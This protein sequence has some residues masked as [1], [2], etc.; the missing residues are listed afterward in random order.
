MTPVLKPSLGL[1]VG[2]LY[3]IDGISPQEAVHAQLPRR[4]S[5]I[6]NAYAWDEDGKNF[7][8]DLLFDLLSY[9]LDWIGYDT[10][11][12]MTEES[13]TRTYPTVD[14]LKTYYQQVPIE[15]GDPFTSLRAVRR[16][17]VTCLIETEFYNRV[18]GP[19]PYHD[20]YVFAFYVSDYRPDELQMLIVRRCAELEIP[21]SEIRQGGRVSA[22]LSGNSA[23]AAASMAMNLFRSVSDVESGV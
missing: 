15:K 13:Q 16:G 8:L 20:Q 23:S 5:L 7:D 12:V 22:V 2:Y 3:D 1:V 17:R 6:L 14:E 9:L 18:G 4:F 19:M 21:I 11:T 10:L